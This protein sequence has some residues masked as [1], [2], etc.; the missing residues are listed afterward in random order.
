MVQNNGLVPC[1]LNVYP[2]FNNRSE[3]SN[4]FVCVCMLSNMKQNPPQLKMIQE[5]D[6]LSLA[7]PQDL[8]L[9]GAY[10]TGVW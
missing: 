7:L 2:Y 5:P 10:A 4:F 9:Y 8:H 6:V 1:S 3:I